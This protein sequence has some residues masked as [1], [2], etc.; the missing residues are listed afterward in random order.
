M[1]FIRSLLSVGSIGNENYFTQK[2]DHFDPSDNRTYQQRYFVNSTFS[3]NNSK[4][5]ILFI[6]GE[7]ELTPTSI[8]KS[9]VRKLAE[10]TG[11]TIVGLEHRFFGK[12]QP[13][14]KLSKENLRYLTV[15]QELEDLASF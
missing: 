14:D 5:L 6:G 12:S 2:I 8:V 9:S 11:S 7:S 10:T 15:E 3:K 13:F 1:N 4:N